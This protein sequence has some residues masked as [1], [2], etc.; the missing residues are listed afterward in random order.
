MEIETWIQESEPDMN[1]KEASHSQWTRV[2]KQGL[3]P[4]LRGTSYEMLTDPSLPADGEEGHV[5]R[6]V[7]TSVCEPY[8]HGIG[9]LRWT[10]SNLWSP[11]KKI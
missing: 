3:P 6:V 10:V 11:K 7:L 5:C 8:L 4:V 1:R 9:S 2:H